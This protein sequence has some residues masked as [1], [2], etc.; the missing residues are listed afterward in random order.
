MKIAFSLAVYAAASLTC[1]LAFAQP[2]YQYNDRYT[3][4]SHLSPA[5]GDSVVQS[6]PSGQTLEERPL[7]EEE[8]RNAKPMGKY[9]D[10]PGTPLTPLPRG[11]NQPPP[12]EPSYYSEP[13]TASGNPGAQ[14][15]A[16]PGYSGSSH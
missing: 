9:I 3:P 11:G 14:P 4:Q 13:G 16:M 5:E 10:A 2:A 15:Q 7:T 6:P 1:S 12:A 8:M